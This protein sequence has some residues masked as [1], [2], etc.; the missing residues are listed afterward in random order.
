ML[1]KNKNSRIPGLIPF[2]ILIIFIYM[3][4]IL[5]SFTGC[6]SVPK[7]TLDFPDYNGYV[8]DYTGTL[9]AEWKT[10]TENLVQAVREETSC[11]I[12]VAVID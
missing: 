10:K 4:T 2:Y 7:Y 9:S 12:A 3:L 1:I 8:N 6:A 11:E 5:V